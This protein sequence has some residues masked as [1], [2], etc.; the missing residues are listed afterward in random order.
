MSKTKKLTLFF[1][2]KKGNISDAEQSFKDAAVLADQ[3]VD[4]IAKNVI[5]TQL[6][7]IQKEQRVETF[8]SI[9]TLRQERREKSFSVEFYS[10]QMFHTLSIEISNIRYRRF[11]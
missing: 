5:Q 2:V 10:V 4:D 1:L 7:Q 9:M 8:F 11:L 3:V 6:A